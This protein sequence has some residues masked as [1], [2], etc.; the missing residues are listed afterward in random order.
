MSLSNIMAIQKQRKVR[1]NQVF[2]DIYEKVKIR[3]NHFTKFNQTSCQYQVPYIIYGLPHINLGD[4]ADYLE[5]KLKDEGFAVIRLTQISIYISWEE[6][7]VIEQANINREKRK[8]RD[9]QKELDSLEEK[10]NK[11]LLRSL[12][13]YD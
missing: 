5:K 4:I 12:V 3:I 8:Q 10:R 9:R 13:S 7:V 11:D 6:S 2:K 1:R